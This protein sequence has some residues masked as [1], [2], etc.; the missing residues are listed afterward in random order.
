MKYVAYRYDPKSMKF[1][2]RDINGQI[3][4][5]GNINV[6]LGRLLTQKHKLQL[7]QANG[8]WLMK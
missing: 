6:S 5:I 2:A 3:Y 7:I 8:D 4:V 1:E